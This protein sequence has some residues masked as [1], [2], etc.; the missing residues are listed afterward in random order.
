ML[1]VKLKTIWF[2]NLLTITIILLSTQG[3]LSMDA[4]KEM[5]IIPATPQ[6]NEYLENKLVEFNQQQVPFTQSEPFMQLSFVIKDEENVIRGGITAVIYCWK[7]LYINVLWVDERY[8]KHGY[9]AKLLAEI[10]QAA[11]DQGC[12]L[13]HL[14]TFDF[15]AKD[16]Y[17]RQ[18]YEIFGQLDDC[19]PGHAKFFM[20][21]HLHKSELR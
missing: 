20:K 12:K 8:R 2:N 10:E 1:F 6:D 11:Y 3:L 15:Q 16:F 5:V 4:K 14:D 9:G 13:A 7:I 18:G 17:L 19:P 21:K